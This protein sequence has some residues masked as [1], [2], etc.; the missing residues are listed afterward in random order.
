V[1]GVVVVA[2]L[3]VTLRAA[4]LTLAPLLSYATAV[5]EYVP[6]GTDDHV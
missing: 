5:R 1:G 3:T 2:A 6:A 4:D